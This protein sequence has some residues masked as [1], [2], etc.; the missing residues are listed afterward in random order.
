MK[1]IILAA[2]QGKR[3]RPITN[4]KPKCLVEINGISILQRILNTANDAG[5]KDII[6]VGGYF[7]EKIKILGKKLI[8]N[9]N[10]GDTNMVMSLFCAE[11]YFGEEFIVSYGDIL[12]PAN[13]IKKLVDSKYN[14]SVVVD[15]NWLKYW[16]QRF[17]EPLIDA[18]KLSIKNNKIIKI[19]GKAEKISQIDSQYIGLLA[20][21]GNGIKQVKEMFKI[22]NYECKNKCLNFGNAKSLKSMFM[23]D[24][25]Q[26][27]IDRNI[28]INP[29]F[30]SGG[31][32]EIDN[33][34]DLKIAELMLKKGIL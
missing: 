5:I 8:F 11:D 18:E 25:L 34:K 17:N 22:A 29:I 7:Y 19:G 6:I 4:E 33:K 13:V 21:K 2:G 31:W 16:K 12:Y 24:F 23:T 3:L 27:M 15:N 26:G 9:K 30:I 32:A 14:I 10:F 20:F 1:L 28:E